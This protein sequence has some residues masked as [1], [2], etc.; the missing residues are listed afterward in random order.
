MPSWKH[1]EHSIKIQTVLQDRG[2]PQGDI[3]I[4]KSW[5]L[6]Q[7]G[8]G[9]SPEWW[10]FLKLVCGVHTPCPLRLL[11]PQAPRTL[12]VGSARRPLK[13]QTSLRCT[14]CAWDRPAPTGLW[15]FQSYPARLVALV[16]V[17]PGFSGDRGWKLVSWST[18][19]WTEWVHEKKKK[20]WKNC[21][22]KN[23][24]WAAV[25]HFIRPFPK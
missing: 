3:Y 21:S 4:Y 19:G 25:R 14:R 24:H 10:I 23:S 2:F 5:E 22:K 17:F 9:F 12:S 11:G 16:H 18:L 13:Q 1:R 6:M 7:A 15:R 8:W 20:T